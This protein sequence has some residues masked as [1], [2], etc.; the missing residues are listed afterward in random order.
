MIGS[1]RRLFGNADVELPTVVGEVTPEAVGFVVRIGSTTGIRRVNQD[2]AVA[3]GPLVA[4]ADGVGGSVR[5]E[6]A[7]QVALG[8]IMIDG[9]LIDP[10]V[11]PAV[12]LAALVQ[13]AHEQALHAREVFNA[14]ES[15]TTLTV[16]HLC[17]RRPTD[18]TPKA[19]TT[20]LVDGPLV[21]LTLAWVG[22]SPAYLVD[23]RGVRQLTRSHTDAADGHAAEGHPLQRAVGGSDATPEIL[24]EVVSGRAR[25][26][27]ATDGILAVPETQRTDLL[28]DLTT[29]AEQCL[30]HLLDAVD[31]HG[32]RD[33]TTIAVVDLTPGTPRERTSH[34]WPRSSIDAPEPS[35]G[36]GDG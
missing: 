16:A 17:E 18:V 9:A 34:A 22:D 31:L 12:A 20:A 19:P 14:I 23:R 21:E 36:E 3:A 13:S 25:L 8:R 4:V 32:G 30:D 29:T 1:L 5:G 2:R 6:A 35:F 11:A 7:A 27:L 24:T 28:A 33:N 26:V 10:H 15:S